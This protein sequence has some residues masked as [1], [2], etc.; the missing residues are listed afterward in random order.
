L[1]RVRFRRLRRSPAIARLVRETVVSIDDLVYPLFIAEADTDAGPI[2]AMPGQLRWSLEGIG[3]EVRE[4]AEL[5]IPAVLLFGIPSAR[6]EIGTGAWAEDG[7]IPRAVAAVRDAAPDLL[8]ITDVCLCE[9]TTHGHCGVVDPGPPMQVDNDATL[10]L[11]Q[12]TAVAHARAGADVVAPS[13]M[14]DGMVAAVRSALDA[15]GYPDVAILS[16]AVKYASAFYGPFREAAGGAPRFGD[17][18]THQ[19]DVANRREALREAV[20]DVAEGADILMVKPALG[21]LDIVRELRDRLD[22]PLAAYN[23]SGEYA[24]VKGAAARGWVDERA[25]VMEILTGMKRA[26]ADLLITYHAREMARW[27]RA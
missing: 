4:V 19:M 2:D 13:G 17:R 23:V 6:D 25:A 22:L 12:R 20:Q 24:M 8:I 9:Y 21:R 16:Y 1:P 7:V 10:P 14:M 15:A 11:L 3:N 26:G 5:G 18:R 27:L